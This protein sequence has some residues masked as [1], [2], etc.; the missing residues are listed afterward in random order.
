MH[1]LALPAE[2][3]NWIWELCV[4]HFER[5]SFQGSFGLKKATQVPIF[6]ETILVD[7][8]PGN[9]DYTPRPPHDSKDA[10]QPAITRVCRQT[11]NEAMQLFYSMNE[12]ELEVLPWYAASTPY[13][14][15]AVYCMA[16]RWINAIGAKNAKHLKKLT[17]LPHDPGNGEMDVRAAIQWFRD[18]GVTH[19]LL[20]VLKKEMILADEKIR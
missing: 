7:T 20:D 2:I 15:R 13:E 1:L 8:P 17:K 16:S 4:V 18:A 9:V 5:R 12:F 3:R 11:R 10:I 6:I 19:D 14:D